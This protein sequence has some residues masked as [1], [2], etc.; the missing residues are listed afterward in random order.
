VTVTRVPRPSAR[1]I[2][3]Y[4]PSVN[5]L[6]RRL[7]H[8]SGQQL[9]AR[10]GAGESGFRGDRTSSAGARGETQFMPATRADYIHRYH[11]DPWANPDQAYHATAIYLKHGG[12][13]P[14]A[15]Y[16]P[17]DPSY[18]GY[19]LGQRVSGLM[20]ANGRVGGAGGSQ[21]A[22]SVQGGALGAYDPAQALA[23]LQ[24]VLGGSSRSQPIIPSGSPM[25]D[26]AAAPV[27]AGGTHLTAEPVPQ[28]AAPSQGPDISQLLTQ[29]AG[30]LGPSLS[31]GGGGGSSAGGAAGG[32]GGAV[33]GP[34][35]HAHGGYAYPL[36]R[37]GKIIGTPYSGTHTLGNWQSDNAVDISVPV[38]TGV[39]SIEDGIVVKITPHPQSAGRFAG[40][41]ITI[42]GK[43]GGTFYTH[44]SSYSVKVGQHV[45][46][47]QQ[48]GRSGSANGVA[49]LHIGRERGNPQK[50][51]G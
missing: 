7:Y 30:V 13:N 5:S 8:I 40:D 10:L 3:R 49:H 19:I 21:G 34:D 15:A 12:H 16:N 39:R 1:A 4:G 26:F 33:A 31:N 28:G 38:G 48:I 51:F 45:R 29:V 23:A 24:G 43:H 17:G 11:V 36:A 9:L 2:A 42:R 22:G 46:R 47:G 32:G 27:S 6:A 44:L 35:G 14:L 37:M 20:H 25:P 18:P 50:E 41:Q